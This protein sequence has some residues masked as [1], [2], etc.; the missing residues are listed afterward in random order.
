MDGIFYPWLAGRD[1]LHFPA[2]GVTHLRSRGLRTLAVLRAQKRDSQRLHIPL[3][4]MGAQPL[5]ADGTAGSRDQPSHAT[6]LLK[7]PSVSPTII[8]RRF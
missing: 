7:L 2:S 1:S 6:K 5:S 4:A 8:G 3:A